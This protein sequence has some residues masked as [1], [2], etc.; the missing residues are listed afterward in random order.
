MEREIMEMRGGFQEPSS[1]ELWLGRA[2]PESNACSTNCGPQLLQSEG[3]N[4]F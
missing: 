3:W 1:E 2:A 4:N